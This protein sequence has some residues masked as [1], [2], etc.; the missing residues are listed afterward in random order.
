MEIY[1]LPFSLSPNTEKLVLYLIKYLVVSKK[2]LIHC[3][4]SFFQS[5]KMVILLAIEHGT[6]KYSKNRF[7]KSMMM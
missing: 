6:V 5:V 7:N 1:I 2:W 4:V 3:K